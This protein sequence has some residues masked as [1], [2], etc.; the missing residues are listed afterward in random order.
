MNIKSEKMNR[1]NRKYTQCKIEW[2][3]ALFWYH[4][5]HFD[6]RFEWAEVLNQSMMRTQM[7]SHISVGLVEFIEELFFWFVED[8]QLIPE[9]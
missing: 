4:V 5:V 1:I 9:L 3:H 8:A 7:L 2:F 6:I